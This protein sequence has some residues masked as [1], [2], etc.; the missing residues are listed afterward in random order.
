MT[1]LFAIVC[2][3]QKYTL[4]TDFLTKD[5]HVIQCIREPKVSQL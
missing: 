2:A 1:L 3:Y 5:R 4:L